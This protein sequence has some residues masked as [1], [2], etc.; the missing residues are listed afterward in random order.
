MTATATP[1]TMSAARLHEVGQPLSIDQVDRPTPGENDV[2]VAVESANIVQNLRNVISTY[3]IDKPFLPLPELPAI[4][5]MDTAGTIVETGAKVRNLRVGD[6][7]YLNPGRS[8]VDSWETRTGDPLSDPAYTFQGY[9]GF[10][11]D[12]V[13]VHRDYPHGALCEYVKAPAS[14]VIGI[15]DGVTTDQASR[16]RAPSGSERPCWRWRWERPACSRSPATSSCS[17]VCARSTPDA[18][19]PSRSAMRTW[20]PGCVRTTTGAERT[21]AS[22]RSTT[23]RRRR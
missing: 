22:T 3:P 16:R 6:R 1:T 18:S 11:P 23:R 9:F 2:I 4:F 7:V 8:A 21:C 15:P 13:E 12:S 17:T 10:G 5:G 19:T 14:A 20:A